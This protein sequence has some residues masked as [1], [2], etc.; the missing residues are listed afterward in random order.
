MNK[1]YIAHA[2]INIDAPS[3]RVWQ[4]LT[5]P[6]LIRQYMFGTTV[7]S[8]W[9]EGS[10]ISWKG[11]WKGKS[12]EDKGT[13][14]RVNPGQ[15]LRYTHFSP[16]SGLEDSPQNYHTVSIQLKESGAQTL[17]SLTQDNNADEAS[18]THSEKN[19]Q[20]ML[21]GLKKVAEEALPNAQSKTG[22]GAN[23]T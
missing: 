7:N 13:I 12:Y 21:E 22:T 20:M 18:K 14:L 17:V 4:A 15:E 10:P 11:E 3:A 5:E 16:L 19:W 8:T 2:Q 1:P 23:E 9:E 6:D